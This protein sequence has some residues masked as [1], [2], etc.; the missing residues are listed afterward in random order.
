MEDYFPSI[1]FPDSPVVVIAEGDLALDSKSANLYSYAISFSL[2]VSTSNN[3]YGCLA[4]GDQILI[5]P[6]TRKPDGMSQHHYN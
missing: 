5:H 6:A 2:H 1:L 4:L 3:S